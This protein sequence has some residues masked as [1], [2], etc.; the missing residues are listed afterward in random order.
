METFRLLWVWVRGISAE[1]VFQSGPL[2][3]IRVQLQKSGQGGGFG[4][5]SVRGRFEGVLEECDT[6]VALLRGG[7]RVG[8]PDLLRG[9]CRELR[10]EFGVCLGKRVQVRGGGAEVFGKLRRKQFVVQ[11]LRLEQDVDLRLGVR[12]GRADVAVFETVCVE[13]GR[14]TRDVARIE[15]GP[16]R[17]DHLV[18]ADDVLEIGQEHIVQVEVAI[19]LDVFQRI[20][21]LLAVQVVEEAE[22]DAGTLHRDLGSGLGTRHEA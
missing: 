6:G 11:A 17:R 12:D 16:C 19:G 9:V 4:L 1:P 5:P 21:V 10:E 20:I 14:R 13:I 22:Q 15:P 3:G 8:L 2:R 7:E 18:C